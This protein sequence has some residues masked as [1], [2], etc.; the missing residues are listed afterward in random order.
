[1]MEEMVRIREASAPDEVLLVVD[2]MIG[3]EAAELTRAFHEQV[4]IR[5]VHDAAGTAIA[6][7]EHACR[8]KAPVRPGDTLATRWI[9]V[10]KLDKPKHG[11]GIVVMK[12]EAKNQHGDIVPQIRPAESHS[13]RPRR[14]RARSRSSHRPPRRRRGGFRR[15][16]SGWCRT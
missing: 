5:P 2:S 4:G 1:M 8:F 3:Q 6:Y 10:D 7:M 12:C 13:R 11:G 16:S 15:R 9:V 14:S